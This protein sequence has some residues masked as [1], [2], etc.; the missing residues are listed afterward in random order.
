MKMEINM[1]YTT[2]KCLPP[3]YDLF[4]IL[5]EGEPNRLGL[6]QNKRRMIFFFFT[7]C[8]LKFEIGKS[9]VS[10]YIFYIYTS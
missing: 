10:L 5:S 8:L 2:K 4:L 7:F 1:W 6:L 3:Y 9:I